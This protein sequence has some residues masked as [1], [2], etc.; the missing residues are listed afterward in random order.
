MNDPTGF[1]LAFGTYEDACAMV[2]T[3][4]DPVVADFP[5]DWGM[6]KHFC[7][8]VHDGNRAYWDEEW[9]TRT[10]GGILSPP[11]MAMTWMMPIVW[12]PDAAEV[13]P[14]LAAQVPLPGASLINV[15]ND[16]E[17]RAPI[18][19]GARLTMTEELVDVSPEKRTVL[20]VGHFVSVRSWIRTTPDQRLVATITNTLFRFSPSSTS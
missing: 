3:R 12:R 13:A 16:A 7:A 2:G 18:L 11:A 8:M 5:V 14:R 20:G 19:G 9:A 10:W 1:G 4:T 17:F 15:S 6:I